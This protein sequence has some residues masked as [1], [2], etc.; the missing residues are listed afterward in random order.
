L[1]V[2][3]QH[4]GVRCLAL[5]ALAVFVTACGAQS[6]PKDEA[7]TAASP[8]STPSS[9]ATASHSAT[10]DPSGSDTPSPETRNTPM[11]FQPG[12]V[13]V[14][15]G[16]SFSAGEG[17]GD[18]EPGTDNVPTADAEYIGATNR[19]HRSKNAYSQKVREALATMGT[20]LEYRFAACSG[21]VISD[22]N[23]DNK[24]TDPVQPPQ[25]DVIDL[26]R[27][28]LV[29]LTFGG[30]D[31]HFADVV[32]ACV[33]SGGCKDT[34]VKAFAATPDIQFKDLYRNLLLEA[35]NAII[36]VM[37]YPRLFDYDNPT[38]QPTDP[39]ITNFIVPDEQ[40]PER[41]HMF[42]DL[43]N[44]LNRRIVRA[45]E[46]V[47]AEFGDEQRLQYI[48]VADVMEGHGVCAN[49]SERFVNQY[50]RNG[51]HGSTWAYQESFHPNVYGQA[52]MGDRVMECIQGVKCGPRYWKPKLGYDVDIKDVHVPIRGGWKLVVDSYT[53]TNE[54]IRINYRHTN[55][56][57]TTDYV[58]C[59]YESSQA[60]ATLQFPNQ[61]V[62]N[63]GDDCTGHEGKKTFVKPGKSIRTWVSFSLDETKEILGGQKFV[64]HAGRVKTGKIVLMK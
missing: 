4:R 63:D 23:H 30:N 51:P 27:T 7:T 58:W 43:V 37:G 62:F 11:E 12:D 33:V 31:A 46:E 53:F 16:D 1:K 22:Y 19:C 17:A 47:N 56:K 45:I 2:R 52:R 48:D 9:S 28:K 39:C 42:N 21:A 24:T 38:Y 36:M 6:T 40:T 55:T 57:S 35:P 64:Y 59:G 18:Y 50:V 15:L 60:Y 8:A 29:T 20:E 10:T 54:G 44:L 25:H 3:T 34:L 13:F 14:A 5:A 32:K 41:Q 26:E 49:S 61:I